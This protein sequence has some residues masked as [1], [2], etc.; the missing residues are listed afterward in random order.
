MKAPVSPPLRDPL[1]HLLGYQLRRASMHTLTG[2]N[3]AFEGLGVRL[4]EAIILRF[5]EA[6]PGCNQA[7]IGRALG[8]TRTNMVPVVAGL[9]DAGLVRREVADGRTHAL[10][11]T[12]DGVALHGRI[13]AA[14]RAHE[15]HFF[16]DID[17]AERAVLM[18]LCQRIRDR[19]LK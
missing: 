17:A 9:V 2:L 7:E 19:P 12:P 18:Q 11:L 10:H 14:T 16:G 4:T 1:D 13:D 3:E 5:V 15:E 6:N 8:V